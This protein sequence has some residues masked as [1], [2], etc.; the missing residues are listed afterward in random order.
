MTGDSGF[1]AATLRLLHGSADVHRNTEIRVSDI[2]NEGLHVIEIIEDRRHR[3]V[4]LDAG[5]DFIRIG[6]LLAVPV[7]AWIEIPAR[8]QDAAL[9]G[10]ADVH[11][12]V[13]Q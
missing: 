6:S 13:L 9:G 10:I 8:P 12:I 7:R 4:T 11:R 2:V 5:D 3:G 1:A